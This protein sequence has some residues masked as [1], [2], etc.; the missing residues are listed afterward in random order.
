MDSK[1]EPKYYTSKLYSCI[2][3][4]DRKRRIQATSKLCS[5]VT[6][7]FVMLSVLFGAITAFFICTTAML[8]C[9]NSPQ[10]QGYVYLNG[11]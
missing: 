5:S 11:E 3:S 9:K 6:D 2:F 7:N 8:Y 4:G 1:S 10:K